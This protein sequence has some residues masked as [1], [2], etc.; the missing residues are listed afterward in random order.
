[1]SLTKLFAATLLVLATPLAGA[2][3]FSSLEERM[4]GDEFNAAGLEQLS[5][6]QLARLNEW[7]RGQWPAA[8]A[9][10]TP[11]PAQADTRGLSQVAASRDAIVD[12]YDGEFTGWTS[13]ATIRLKN[14]MVWETLDNARPLSIRPVQDPTVIIEPALMGS[15]LMRV[16]GYNASVRVKRL[17]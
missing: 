3:E 8:A 4:S 13:G 11:Y 2:S 12:Q 5:P 16:E 17:R 15:W 10:A 9:A 6:D 1:M 14:G 7:L